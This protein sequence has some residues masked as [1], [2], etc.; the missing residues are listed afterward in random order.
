MPCMKIVHAIGALSLHVTVLL[1]AH[2]F[3]QRIGEEIVALM[4]DEWV[5]L[6]FD[7]VAQAVASAH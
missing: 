3:M 6:I 7:K 2:A 4:R 1:A 5:V